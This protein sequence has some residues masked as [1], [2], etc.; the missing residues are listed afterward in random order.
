[1]AEIKPGGEPVS[2]YGLSTE[3]YSIA[4]KLAAK[5]H[6]V[7]VID[8]TLG[9]AMVL[10]PGIAADYPELRLLLT[11]EPLLTM[12]TSKESI[13]SA[14]VV[15]FTPKLRRRNEEQISEIKSRLT[16]VARNLKPGCLFVFCLPL[17]IGGTKDIVDRIE[18]GSGL[19]NGK[20]FVFSY[21]PLEA[22]KPT[23]FGCDQAITE[24]M[25]VI[26]DAG[27][28]TEVVGISKAEIVHAQRMIA[29]Y[30]SLA[31]AF[32]ASRRLTLLGFESPR[33]YR[34]VF[35]DELS[36]GLYDLKVVVESVETGDPFLYL[37]SGS[38]KSVE[39][40]ARFLVERIRELVK[41][42]DLKAARLKIMLFTDSDNL[43]MRGDKMS[44]AN[45]VQERLQ[46]FFSDIE[47]LNIMKEGFSFPTGVEK[48]NLMV[49]LS[50]S[51]EQ[52]LIQLYEEQISMTKSHMVRANLPVEFVK[53][54]K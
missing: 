29:R 1:L 3:G 5:G 43:E 42:R 53:G 24:R 16:E 46:D 26:S 51:S 32:E 12:K 45:S 37:G 30:S 17:G 50:G 6:E 52:R 4:A 8:E 9:S 18:H 10:W 20:D 36:G 49:F 22:G 2:I 11:E 48:T 54:S 21:A 39:G 28:L 25:Q 40:Y 31:S 44:L 35:A 23:T 47:Y 19:T 27:L 13:S 41:S 38:L 33:E 7:S 15:F 14:G 34:Q